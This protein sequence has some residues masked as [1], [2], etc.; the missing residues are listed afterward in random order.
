M[1]AYHQLLTRDQGQRAHS[2]TIA[3]PPSSE[4]LGLILQLAPLNSTYNIW[5][6]LTIPSPLSPAH[7][8]GLLPHSDYILG[9]PSGTLRG[10]SALG[11]LV[12]D[13]LNRSLVL[14]VYNSEFDVVREVDLIPRRG[15]GGEGAL[16]AVLG[17]GALHR[18]PVGLTDEV[19]APGE[20][21][22]DAER[23]S[24]DRLY[25]GRDE[26]FQQ[27]RLPVA[28]PPMVNPNIPPPVMSPDTAPQP[29]APSRARK[30]KH[31]GALSPNSGFDDMFAEGQKKSAEQDHMPSRKGT[32]LAPPP[33][34]GSAPG[35]PK[36]GRDEVRDPINAAG[37][38]L[39]EPG[40]A[41]EA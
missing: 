31:H 33:K 21:L 34:L 2:L 24:T 15:W 23:K 29:A 30:G 10:E 16:G 18:L 6:I 37:E 11:E 27:A 40:D 13:H 38:D 36:G 32:P 1:I 12:E 19:Q 9:S 17:Y 39:G 25:N 4:S 41:E 35:T 26:S 28:P 14:W 5:H 22:F 20:K 3:V 7:V 8:A